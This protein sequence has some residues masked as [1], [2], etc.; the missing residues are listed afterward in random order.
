MFKQ[1]LGNHLT[2]EIN[3]QLYAETTVGSKPCGHFSTHS[4]D[5]VGRYF[6]IALAKDT[7]LHSIAQEFLQEKLVAIS[8]RK[9]IP[10]MVPF[11][12]PNFGVNDKELCFIACMQA[13]MIGY[14]VLESFL[15]IALFAYDT[16]QVGIE[17]LHVCFH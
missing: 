17:L 3:N 10:A 5:C 12:G 1:S 6:Y 8:Q 2:V 13:D 15:R 9:D 4:N 16:L 11:K 7:A 14:R